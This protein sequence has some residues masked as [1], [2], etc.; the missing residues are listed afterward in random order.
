MLF[1]FLY[2]SSKIDLVLRLKENMDMHAYVN[3]KNSP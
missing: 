2:R 3:G 1:Y